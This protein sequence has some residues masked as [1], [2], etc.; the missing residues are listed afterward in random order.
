MRN[1][2]K[3]TSRSPRFAASATAAILLAGIFYVVAAPP[4]AYASSSPGVWNVASVPSPAGS[5]FA[6]DYAGGQWIALGH[7]ANVAVSPDGSTWSEYPVPAGSWDSVAYGNGR[8][9]ALSSVNASVEEMT[10][11]N[12][13]NWT[14]MTGPSGPW[15]GLTFG[16]GRFVAVSSDGDIETSPDGV[17]W[18]STWS[19]SNYDLSSVTYGDGLFV[20]VDTAMGATIVST[21]GSDWSRILAP[22]S[23]LQW[24][25]VAYG[26]GTYVALDDTGSGYY[27]TS[28]EG[29]VWTLHRYSPPQDTVGA[30]FGCGNF[31]A[32][33]SPSGSTNN[34]ISSSTG[35]SWAATPVPSDA[36]SDW[37]AVGYGAHR[38]VAVD[39][40]GGIAWSSSAANCA[41]TIPTS[42]QQV[43]G[44]VHNGQVSTYMHPSAH[45]GGAAID[46]YL[47]TIS[48][49]IVTKHCTAPVSYQPNCTISGLSNHEIYSVTTQAHNRFGYS[50]SSDPEFVIPVAKWSL[51]AV[52]SSATTS[53]STPVVV[54]VTGVIAN[55]Q[56][57]YPTSEVAVHFGANLAHCHPNPF[58][59]C[60]VTITNPPT[61]TISLFA[62]YTGYGQ[63]YESPMSHVTIGP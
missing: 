15:A 48:N 4:V 30:T 55:S 8:Y 26:N 13:S 7:S 57:I 58:G 38:F 23:G 33:G 49:G 60:L 56:G 53:Q 51:S 42:P 11:T 50:T 39:S 59:E 18:T 20:A 47:V 24:G 17:N 21:N 28:I 12:G 40:A 54:Q 19:H 5:W 3:R 22:I 6:V 35:Q 41:A 36:T 52:T 16:E 46:S 44:N 27:E 10:S 31:V 43:S 2:D 61:G 62:T 29:H 14:P 32:V 34:I 9:V 63:T 1:R 45:A 25:A 37:T